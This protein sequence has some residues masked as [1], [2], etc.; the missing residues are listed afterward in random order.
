MLALRG[1]LGNC[2][3]CLEGRGI[4]AGLLSLH[5]PLQFSGLDHRLPQS[6]IRDAAVTAAAA[7]DICVFWPQNISDHQNP[8]SWGRDVF[9]PRDVN[10]G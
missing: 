9:P 1:A 2:D 7:V 6:D 8:R 5:H 10:A 4:T 3:Y